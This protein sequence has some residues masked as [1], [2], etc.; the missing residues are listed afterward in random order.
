MPPD[1][2]G[3]LDDIIEAA[4]YIA[5]DTSGITYDVFMRDRR[6][7]QAVERNFLTIGKLSTDC[8]VMRQILPPS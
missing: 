1:I 5:E 2:L 4:D 6:I 7:R 8:A 3:V